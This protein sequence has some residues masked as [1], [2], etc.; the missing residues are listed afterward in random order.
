MPEPLRGLRVPWCRRHPGSGRLNAFRVEAR[1]RVWCCLS[2]ALPCSLA[3]ACAHTHTQRC[4]LKALLDPRLLCPAPAVAAPLGVPTPLT[5]PFPTISPELSAASSLQPACQTSTRVCTPVSL[6][7]CA[8]SGPRVRALPA[9]SPREPSPSG[10]HLGQVEFPT[11]ASG[12]D[13][14]MLGEQETLPLALL[15]QRQRPQAAPGD[16]ALLRHG[17]LD[18]GACGWRTDPEPSSQGHARLWPN[19]GTRESR[20][21]AAGALGRT[22]P[23]P[24]GQGP[25]RRRSPPGQG[26][27]GGHAGLG[28]VLGGST[29]GELALAQMGQHHA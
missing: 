26:P 17:H 15:L 27:C 16:L 21:L 24:P 9:A 12:A 6:R 18:E 25:G 1:E 5:L 14:Q 23:P 29:R 19:A 2:P 20:F 22:P 28:W 10:P 3:H 7:P 8:L 11:G 4:T 13:N